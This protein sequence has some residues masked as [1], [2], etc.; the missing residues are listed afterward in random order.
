MNQRL[1]F[2]VKA[3]AAHRRRSS[4]RLDRLRLVLDDLAARVLDRLDDSAVRFTAALDIGGR[5]AV[6]PFLAA[7]GIT[8]T[9]ADLA[10]PI[11]A[12]VLIDAEA[13]P[14]AER[15][16]DLIVAHCSLHWVNDLPGTLVQL[17]RIL[18]PGGLFLASL[19]LA[20]TLAELRTALLEADSLLSGG[21]PP[22]IA[23]FPDLADCAALLQRAGFALP[24]A[25]RDMIRFEY[26]DRLGMLRDLQDAG[27]TNA[28]LAR[29]RTI[30]PRLLFPQA[31][32]SLASAEAP[33]TIT[34][35]L[36][37]LT[38]WAS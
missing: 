29:T 3:V 22:R 18:R 4:R 35:Q 2:D 25:E 21:A 15:S 5:G 20:G 11:D 26:R 6:A 7:R 9:R 13:I 1:I 32:A 10:T 19:P 23:P 31:L 30:P 14:F 34:L 37:V 38:G 17:R 12:D 36:G 8:V 28:L 33:A 16:F 27:E 24:V